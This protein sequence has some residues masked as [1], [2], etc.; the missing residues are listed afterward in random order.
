[1]ILC[2]VWTSMD[3]DD[4]YSSPILACII[5]SLSNAC[6]TQKSTLEKFGPSG[7]FI[8]RTYWQSIIMMISK[9]NN[10]FVNFSSVFWL[11]K[12]QPTQTDLVG[13]R[14]F[15]SHV[16]IGKESFEGID[17]TIVA[18]SS[19]VM[20]CA[21]NA[22]KL[23]GRVI[24][25][26]NGHN[27]ALIAEE[28]A[29]EIGSKGIKVKNLANKVAVSSNG[30]VMYSKLRNDGGANACDFILLVQHNAWDEESQNL[31]EF[32]MQ[33][34]CDAKVMMNVDLAI[35]DSGCRVSISG[36]VVGYDKCMRSWIVKRR[37]VDVQNCTF[38]ATAESHKVVERPDTNR[39]K[40]LSAV[41]IIELCIASVLSCTKTLWYMM[42]KWEKSS[43]SPSPENCGGWPPNV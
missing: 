11:T 35:L 5:I 9:N 1:M 22:F 4:N 27:T 12:E 23:D 39:Q 32:V 37:R 8:I 25:Q 36:N 24:S 28:T 21:D 33:Y 7:V 30:I 43:A 29:I 42:C 17:L 13:R 3:H 14:K 15:G 19:K 20:L 41:E 18:P 38:F 6:F 31:V 40:D 34:D 26:C 10:L 2:K 16:I